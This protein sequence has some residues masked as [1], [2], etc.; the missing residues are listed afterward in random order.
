MIFITG[1][2]NKAREVEMMIGRKIEFQSIDLPEIQALHVSDVVRDKAQRAYDVVQ[3][4][5]LVEDSGIVINSWNGLPGACTKWF[6]KSVGS[7]GITKMIGDQDRTAQAMTIFDYYDGTNHIICE[8]VVNGTIAQIPL[9]ENG[10]GWDDI[11]IPEGQSKTFAQM[12]NQE[13]NEISMRKI[14]I[15]KL[16]TCLKSLS[17]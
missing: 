16:K 10:F 15:D 2:Q 13:K 9:G 11:F 5:V 12:S 17:H 3:K 7:E 4:P 6:M 14:A 1:N 8:G